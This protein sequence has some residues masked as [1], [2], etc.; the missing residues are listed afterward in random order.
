M[1]SQD[2]ETTLKSYGAAAIIGT[3]AVLKSIVILGGVCPFRFKETIT[4]LFD[5]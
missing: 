4:I 1:V 5:E 3:I 2:S